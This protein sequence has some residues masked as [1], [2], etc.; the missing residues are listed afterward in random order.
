MDFPNVF[1]TIAPGEWIFSLQEAVVGNLEVPAGF[2][3]AAAL[4]HCDGLL[5]LH[6]YNVPTT[7]FSQLSLRKGV[8]VEEAYE[9]V[10]RVEF[11][12]R[13]TLH[14]HIT[15]LSGRWAR[16]GLDSVVIQLR[17]GCPERAGI[18]L[19]LWSPMVWARAG[20]IWNMVTWW[21]TR[22]SLSSCRAAMKMLTA[23]WML[24]CLWNYLAC[25]L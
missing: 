25:T 8:F 7:M 4:E 16:L 18:E 15:L 20:G 22:W 12:G 2:S 21:L 1:S 5:A 14:V 11:Q 19:V 3:N 17:G 23:E 24:C 9:H 6:L 13:G 10:L